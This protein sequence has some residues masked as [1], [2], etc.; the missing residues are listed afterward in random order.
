MDEVWS[1]CMNHE[2]LDTFEETYKIRP[3]TAAQ[4]SSV[5][6][7]PP[8]S[9]IKTTIYGFSERCTG[10]I[11]GWAVVYLRSRDTISETPP[12][13][14]IFTSS[15][16]HAAFER[17][18]EA[19]YLL[20]RHAIDSLGHEILDTRV[21]SDSVYGLSDGMYGFD[22]VQISKRHLLIEQTDASNVYRITKDKWPH[23]M[24]AGG[25]YLCTRNEQTA[26]SSGATWSMADIGASH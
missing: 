9:C 11:V 26:T 3:S 8:P 18:M 22:I 4:F 20:W 19:V 25:A 13:S 1:T 21:V 7:K 16:G 17:N 6:Q 15:R 12:R 5:I 2:N 10:E 23:L 24:K 14:A